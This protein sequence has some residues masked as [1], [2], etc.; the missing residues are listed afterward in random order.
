M[1]LITSIDY[2]YPFFPPLFSFPLS[3]D[4]NTFL[5]EVVNF[6]IVLLSSQM[7]RPLPNA[8][9]NNLFMDI[10]FHEHFSKKVDIIVFTQKLL[11]YYIKL[12]VPLPSPSLIQ[13]LGTAAC[14]LNFH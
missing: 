12:S 9:Q 13:Q 6:I 8:L 1:R 10:A 4:L 11:N 7:F 5:V 2:R 14:I 3:E